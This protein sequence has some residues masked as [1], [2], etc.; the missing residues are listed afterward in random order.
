MSRCLS[1]YLSI[2]LSLSGT[3]YRKEFSGIH[4]DNRDAR[5]HAGH[6]AASA[7][8]QLEL[9][10]AVGCILSCCAVY[11]LTQRCDG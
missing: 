3:V 11:S 5:S 1:I 4:L 8:D 6:A 7:S 2:Y 9:S 10:I